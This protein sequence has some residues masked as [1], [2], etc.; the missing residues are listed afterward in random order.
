MPGLGTVGLARQGTPLRLVVVP[1]APAISLPLSLRAKSAPAISRDSNT[2]EGA[3]EVLG[4]I[5]VSAVPSTPAGEDLLL[6]RVAKDWDVPIRASPE[7]LTYTAEPWVAPELP[8][9]ESTVA[10]PLTDDEV[11]AEAELVAVSGAWRDQVSSA[12]ESVLSEV[13][14][15][16]SKSVRNSTRSVYEGTWRVWEESFGRSAER[17]HLP[18]REDFYLE[19]VPGQAVRNLVAALFVVHL[20][21]VLGKKAHQI[22]QAICAMRFF[23]GCRNQCTQLF[24]CDLVK[25]AKDACVMSPDEARALAAKRQE[26]DPRMSIPAELIM[27]LHAE[28]GTSW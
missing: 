20:A 15:L 12:E 8:L 25:R 11:E 18:G 14:A 9:E 4:R 7:K 24:M 10:E 17:I 5:S 19:R 2:D 22:G 27:V 13:S 21:N 3:V 23:F 1:L 16:A 26:R 28:L 6:T